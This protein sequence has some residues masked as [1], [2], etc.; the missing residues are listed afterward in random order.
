MDI[1]RYYEIRLEGHLADRWSEWFEGLAVCKHPN[2]ET[3]LRGA[4]IDQSALFGVLT[5]IHDLNLVLVS[6]RRVTSVDQANIVDEQGE[7]SEEEIVL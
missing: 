1:P 6:V 2:S 4:L 7:D 3:I 5:R